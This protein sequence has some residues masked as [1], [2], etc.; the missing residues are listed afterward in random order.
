VRDCIERHISPQQLAEFRAQEDAE[1]QELI[2]IAG[3]AA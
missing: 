1:R 2:D 3:H